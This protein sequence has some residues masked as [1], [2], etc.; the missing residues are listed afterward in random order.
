M[1]QLAILGSSGDIATAEESQL[2]S[3]LGSLAAQSGYT[4]LVGGDDGIMGAA[5]R[6]AF[7]E[8]GQVVAVLASGKSLGSARE[9][10]AVIKT[11]LPFGTFSQVLLS[12]CDAAVVIGGGAGTLAEIC[13]AYLNDIPL[14][15]LGADSIL[16]R[17][18][19]DEILPDNRKLR[20]I[21]VYRDCRGLLAWLKGQ[22]GH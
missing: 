22:F 14:A 15:V 3:E 17:L 8:S 20:K 21:P 19:A 1:K 7:K 11:G 9:F 5:A 4:C 10:A 13:F 2:A 18:I 12:S 16:S 6:A